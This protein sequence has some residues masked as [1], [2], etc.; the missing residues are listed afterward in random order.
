MCRWISRVRVKGKNDAIDIYEPLNTWRKVQ[1]NERELYDSHNKLK[2]LIEQNRIDEARR[3][4]SS[5]W[6][7]YPKDTV[8]KE[9]YQ[10][11]H[12][13]EFDPVLSLY[14]K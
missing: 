4:I 12:Q 9:L 5:L 13:P 14:S 2:L 10:R 11:L 8:V 1:D 3:L 6:R 7:N